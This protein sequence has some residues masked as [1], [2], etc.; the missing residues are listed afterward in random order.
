MSEI[1][2]NYLEELTLELFM[3]EKSGVTCKKCARFKSS[4][5]YELLPKAWRYLGID[6]DSFKFELLPFDWNAP[7]LQRHSKEKV[8]WIQS[9]FRRRNSDYNL[10][11]IL[12]KRPIELTEKELKFKEKFH[13]L[14]RAWGDVELLE[15]FLDFFRDF[16]NSPALRMHIRWAG[17][18]ET[19][20][21]MLEGLKAPRDPIDFFK[22]LNFKIYQKA[23]QES[24]NSEIFHEKALQEK[25]ADNIPLLATEVKSE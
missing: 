17:M 9:E 24:K 5:V 14:P 13:S 10:D 4:K 18:P 20:V 21:I 15:N 1:E 12:H 7:F 6:K 23:M 22:F 11:V 8:E 25:I 16:D 3:V 2:T 19:S